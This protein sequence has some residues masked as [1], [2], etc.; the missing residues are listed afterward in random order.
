MLEHRAPHCPLS[1]PDAAQHREPTVSPGLSVVPVTDRGLLLLQARAADTWLEGIL[2]RQLGLHLPAPLKA[3]RRDAAAMLWL[4]PREWL[5]ELPAAAT[6]SVHAVLDDSF[7]EARVRLRGQSPPSLCTANDLSDAFAGLDVSGTRA[8]DVL[9]S[10]CSLPLGPQSFPAG[11]VARTVLAEAPVI[12]WRA[13]DSPGCG[14]FRCWAE[15]SLAAHL[16]SWLAESPTR[17]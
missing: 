8:I 7:A 5:L 13:S 10:G 1:P 14:V 3:S 9:M 11:H 4:A 15:R 12:L 17:W 16:A 6:P 2:H